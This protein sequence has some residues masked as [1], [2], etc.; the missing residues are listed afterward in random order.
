MSVALS[1]QLIYI[2][3]MI[4]Q[5]KSAIFI[6]SACLL[7]GLDLVI[8]YPVTLKMGF[9][10]I[11]FIES[12]FGLVLL[13]PW[14]FKHRHEFR[15]LKRSEWLIAAFV[16]GFG[17]TVGG[18]LQI[19][20]IQKATPGLFSFFQIFQPLFVIFAAWLFLKERVDN[21]YYFWGVWVIL[22]ALM[23]FSVDLTLM[24]DSEIIPQDILIAL[25]TML[26]WGLC[27]LLAKRFLSQHSPMVLVSLRWVFGLAFCVGLLVYEGGANFGDLSEVGIWWRFFYMIVGGV[28]S[29]ALYYSGLKNVL[30]SKATLIEISY[31]AFGMIFSSIYTFEALSFLQTL[32][33]GSFFAF[34]T[35][36]LS[37]D[38]SAIPAVRT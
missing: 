8:R 36:L 3:P 6:L 13:S 18:Y 21:L 11:V 24:Y 28:G 25:T 15:A 38:E 19:V 10:T 30:A 12:F 4:I 20:C 37:K 31:A 34:I 33:A 22:S 29:M 5:R 23:M 26:I 32:G 1:V 2:K 14:I 27:T 17:M 7:W 16:G 35:L 9:T